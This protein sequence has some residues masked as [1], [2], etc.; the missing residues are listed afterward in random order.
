MRLLDRQHPGR[1]LAVAVLALALPLGVA[2]CGSEQDGAASPGGGTTAKATTQLTIEVKASR[3]AEPERFTLTCGD[4]GAQA[5]GTHPRPARACAA[6]E[7]AK[8]PFAPTP[9]SM[10]CTE[11]FGGDQTA[12]IRGTWQGENV[13]AS[14]S[15]ANGCEIGRWDAI[16]AV[17]PVKVGM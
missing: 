5:G 8:H 17:F 10:A 4:T 15:R 9:D 6:L 7:R 11:I 14:Y 12:T 3:N 13:D 1:G 2:A 16:A